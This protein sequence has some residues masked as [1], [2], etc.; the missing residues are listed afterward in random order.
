MITAIVP[1]L[2]TLKLQTSLFSQCHEVGGQAGGVEAAPAGCHIVALRDG[3]GAPVEAQF[4]VVGRRGR[5]ARRRDVMEIAAVTRAGSDLVEQGVK[6]ADY[7][8]AVLRRLLVGQRDHCSPHGGRSRGAANGEPATAARAWQAGA[9]RA[10]G[11]DRAVDGIAGGRVGVQRDIGRLAHAVGVGVLHA[12]TRLPRRLLPVLAQAAAACA[13]E[14]AVVPH[15]FRLV[16]VIAVE[17]KRGTAHAGDVGLRRRVICYQRGVV[18]LLETGLAAAIASSDEDGLALSRR[19]LEEGILLLRLLL[20]GCRL[21]LAPA[22]ADDRRA[23]IDD[24]GKF[25]VVAL[26]GVWRFVDNQFR[27]VGGHAQNDFYVQFDFNCARAGLAVEA[28]Q[29]DVLQRHVAAAEALCIRLDIAGRIAIQF[30]DADR[31]TLSLQTGAVQPVIVVGGGKLARN[32]GHLAAAQQ[33]AAAAAAARRRA[34]AGLRAAHAAVLR[35]DG[36]MR[37]LTGVVQAGE[38]GDI[39]GNVGRQRGV[40]AI[41]EEVAAIRPLIAVDMHAKNALGQRLRPAEVDQQTVG[42]RLRDP[43]ALLCQIVDDRLLLIRRR[44]KFLRELRD[45]QILVVLRRGWIIEILQQGVQLVLIAQRQ[46]DAHLQRPILPVIAQQ[47]AQLNQGREIADIHRAKT[48]RRLR[49]GDGVARIQQATDEQDERE[50][51]RYYELVTHNTLLTKFEETESHYPLALK[52]RGLL[53]KSQI[54]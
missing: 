51:E 10:V 43:E 27:Q 26:C 47:L 7:S 54:A 44:A 34:I 8:L 46:A 39:L 19:L 40:A 29:H 38:R 30:K 36:G 17:R 49:A 52:E 48:T 31:L 6:E 1:A 13:A 9:A 20:P 24:A 21:A 16:A 5:V 3:V 23:I 22:H 53:D 12:G 35:N 45:G 15:V 14:E 32:I 28:I 11:A 25:V 37:E 41:G 42:V 2:L 4:V 18:G 33:A 50:R